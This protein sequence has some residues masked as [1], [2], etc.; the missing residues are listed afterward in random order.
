MDMVLKCLGLEDL[1]QEA[2]EEVVVRA[3]A[4][5]LD[6]VQVDQDQD[7]ALAQEQEEVKQVVL[8]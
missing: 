6:Q 5:A 2:V 7:R 4:Q 8:A 1:A 3:Q